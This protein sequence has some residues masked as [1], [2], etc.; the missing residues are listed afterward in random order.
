MAV[1]I[2]P[3]LERRCSSSR[4]TRA[5]AGAPTRDHDGGDATISISPQ[6]I[7]RNTPI[8]VLEHKSTMFHERLELVDDSGGAGRYRGGARRAARVSFLAT[9]ECSR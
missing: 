2:A 5:S 1:G 7:V 6:S 4:T 3:R 8:E 9:G